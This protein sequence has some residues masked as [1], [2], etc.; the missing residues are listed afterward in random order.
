ME[1]QYNTFIQRGWPSRIASIYSGWKA[2][3]IKQK[4]FIIKYVVFE[5]DQKENAI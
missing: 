2:P 4:Q 3:P 1:K 5:V